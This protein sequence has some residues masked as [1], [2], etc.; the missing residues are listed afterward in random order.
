M[1]IDFVIPWVNGNDIQ[2]Q[3]HRNLYQTTADKIDESRYRDWDILKYWFRSVEKYAPWVN[4]IFFITCGQKP[5]WLN[6][7]HPKLRFIEHK[8]FIPSVYLPT[9]NSMTIELNFHRIPDLSEHFVY[10]NDDMY[11]NRP[12]LPTDFF[13]NDLPL[14]TAVMTP[15]SPSLVYDPHIHAI[16]NDMAFINAHFKKSAVLKASPFKWYNLKYGKGIIKNILNT[17]GTLFSCFSNPHLCS[18]MLKSTYEEVWSLAPDVLDI[19]CKN[20]FR[21]PNSVNQYIMTYYNLCSG[22]FIPQRANFGVCY[23]IGTNSAAMNMDIRCSQHKTIC[24]NDN[25]N[26]LDFEQEKARLIKSF[27]SVFPNKSSYEI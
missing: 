6:F 16:C 24:V 22:K 26:V 13:R 11:L 18:S 27:D 21:S 8:D 14:I 5:E 23:E 4:H 2:W 12:V 7:D 10:F 25:E 15:L 19:S 17:P 1:K 20:R 3:Q 9:F